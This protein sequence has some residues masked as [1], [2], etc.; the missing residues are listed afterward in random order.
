[1]D[2]A[3]LSTK[4]PTPPGSFITET[5]PDVAHR[6][7]EE[8][9]GLPVLNGKTWNVEVTIWPAQA[10]AILVAMPNQRTFYPNH[11]AWFAEMIRSGDFELT[12]QGI[13][14]DKAG[15]LLDGQ[16]R[17]SA[18]IDADTAITVQAT[19]NLD[20]KLF[21]AMDR[22]R[23]RSFADDLV[24]GS[25]AKNGVQAGILATAARFLYQYDRGNDLAVAPNRAAFR[26]QQ[27]RESLARHPFIQDAVSFVAANHNRWKGLGPGP[28]SALYSL[29]HEA[30]PVKAETFIDQVLKGDDPNSCRPAYMFREYLK[31]LGTAHGRKRQAKAIIAFIRCWNAYVEGRDI[32]KVIGQLRPKDPQPKISK[33]K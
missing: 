13:A 25:I 29:I 31:E 30:S 28:A 27:I 6:R 9:L 16:H 26:A 8:I 33:G 15:L 20:R 12:H 18:C 4:P 5:T 21:E 1:M 22:G 19:F 14:F 2:T 23:K 3:L 11:A 10:K 24:C 17:L 7:G 32:T